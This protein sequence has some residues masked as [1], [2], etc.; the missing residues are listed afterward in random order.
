MNT[1]TLVHTAEKT[2]NLFPMTDE[3]LENWFASAGLSVETVGHCGSAPCAICFPARQTEFSQ[4]ATR[5][6]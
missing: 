6:A 2:E 4:G 1:M 3:E 5:A